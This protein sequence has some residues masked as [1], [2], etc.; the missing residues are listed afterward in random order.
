MSGEPESVLIL[1]IEPV[2]HQVKGS[3]AAHDAVPDIF[4]QLGFQ[5]IG[6][7]SDALARAGALVHC[8]IDSPRHATIVA[9]LDTGAAID[10]PIPHNRPDLSDHL[11][12]QGFV[13]V[14]ITPDPI[15]HDGLLDRGLFDGDSARGHV[16][17]A[18]V[19]V[20]RD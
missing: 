18:E 3:G 9:R 5:T 19:V 17:G 13:N 8:R 6:R 2:A 4:T 11:S 20:M 12:A 10:V 7:L 1:Q 16:M 15:G 14:H